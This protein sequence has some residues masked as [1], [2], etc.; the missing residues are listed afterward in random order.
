VTLPDRTIALVLADPPWPPLTG[1]DLRNAAIARAL[2]PLGRLRV[3]LFPLR[4]DPDPSSLPPE[5][6]TFPMR[7]A[8]GR[9]DRVTRRTV[10]TIHGRHPMLDWIYRRGGIDRLRETCDE[11][12]PDAVVLTYPFLGGVARDLRAPGRHVIVDL[13]TSRELTDRRRLGAATSVPDRAKAAL[14][15]LVARRMEAGLGDADEVWVVSEQGA[16][17]LARRR[18]G[19]RPR[20]VPNV[21]D[22][23]AYRPFRNATSR[24]NTFVFVGSLSYSPN[25]DAARW[26]ARTL[27][28]AVRRR[29]PDA[30][31]AIVGRSGAEALNR[32]L[33]ATPGVRLVLD[34]DDVWSVA[35]G[36]GPLV[37]PIRS[38]GGSRFKILE[39]MACGIPV[40]STAMGMEGLDLRPGEG[41]LP[42]EDT[43]AFAAALE[44]LWSDASAGATIAAS[45][46][47][48]VE[49][50]Y[51]Q[52]V[53]DRAVAKA[54]D[55]VLAGSPS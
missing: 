45:A 33:A 9:L 17:D 30:E 40:V 12:R 35:S 4:R 20:I 50:H 46:L 19:L 6:L 25:A 14:D 31:L 3:V 11:I 16:R 41:Y 23:D 8:S 21:I 13:D 15:L 55:R 28:P 36:F 49:S 39:A 37:V 34:A 42:A 18:P 32:E 5:T 44:R 47:A 2:A 53:A 48:F 1:G 7:L 26:L 29:R 38:G 52:A 51:T 54:L 22:L 27:L 10:A 43:A 24:P